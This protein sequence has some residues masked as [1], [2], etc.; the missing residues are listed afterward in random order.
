MYSALTEHGIPS[1]L[2]L[3]HGENHE[4]SRSGKPLHRLRRLREITD[5][6]ERYAR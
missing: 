2:V 4:L 1:R 3:F 6:F 5:W